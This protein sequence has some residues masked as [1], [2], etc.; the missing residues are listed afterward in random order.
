[1][2][3]FFVRLHHAGWTPAQLAAIRDAAERWGFDGISL[4]DVPSRGALECWTALA[5]LLGASD[6]LL[7][8]PLVLANPLR[9]PA[10]VAKMAWDLNELTAGRVVLGLGAGGAPED[11]RAYG[12]P[13]AG[14]L[15]RLR[16]LHEALALTCWLFSGDRV[17]HRGQH[18]RVEGLQLGGAGPPP[19]IL[20]GGHG[21]RLLE[22]AARLAD[23]VNVGFDLAPEDWLRLRDR[24][25][26]IRRQARP[27]AEP[28][29]LSHN[30][31]I[32]AGGSL[33]HWAPTLGQLRAAGVDWFFLV[34]AD[35]PRT[36]LLER[37]GREVLPAARA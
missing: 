15:A 10:L 25:E 16:Q 7:G 20:V 36:E 32:G 31:S 5:H 30:A 2:P 8:V 28:L 37:F 27:E 29:V 18:Y 26:G 22:I 24:L 4:Y 14:L 11:L 35:L 9:H 21:P 34:F 3:R 6:R 23:A 13:D 17:E 12:L 19:P 33:D 1:M